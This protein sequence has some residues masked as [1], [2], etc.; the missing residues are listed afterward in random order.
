MDILES[1]LLPYLRVN[2][3][4]TTLSHSPL[5]HREHDL[6]TAVTSMLGIP[7]QDH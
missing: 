3:A 5:Q 1:P 7:D 2:H 4:L 6:P